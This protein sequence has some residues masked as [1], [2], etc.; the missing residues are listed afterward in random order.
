MTRFAAVSLPIL[1]ALQLGGCAASPAGFPLPAGVSAD[2]VR[3]RIVSPG[4]RHRYVWSSTGPWAIHIVEVRPSACGV[5]LR[6]MK[7]EERLAGRE[8]TSSLARRAAASSNRSALVAVNAD[9]YSSQPPGIPIGPHV[10]D[11]EVVKGHG[12]HPEV[13]ESTIV[14]GTEVFGITERGTPF[15][16]TVRLAGELRIGASAPGAIGAVNARPAQGGWSLYNRYSDDV[17]PTD[18]GA[19]EVVVRRLEPP[20]AAGRQ[21]TGIVTGVDTSPDG[22]RI[23]ADGVVLAAREAMHAVRARVG[24][25]VRWSLPF[26]G[27]PGSV[28]DLVGGFPRLLE[29]DTSLLPGNER[30]RPAFATERH[31]RTAVG[32]RRDGSVLLVTVDGRQ[33]GF[34]EGMTLPELVELMRALGT[35]RALNL[36]GGGS[37]AMVVE[38]VLVNRPSDET[39][40]RAV[41]NALVLLGPEPGRCR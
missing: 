38:G 3:E 9:F 36:D 18:S 12:P 24:D 20:A 30:L 11:G 22:V 35:P 10:G 7:G 13:V 39:G 2:T 26:E 32:I 27:A 6:A 25:T 4:V 17:T 28:T 15:I 40:E 21:E 37:T 41:A 1:L 33:P 31:P 8:L 29:A 5:E 14:P 16:G 19:F 34:S 23:P